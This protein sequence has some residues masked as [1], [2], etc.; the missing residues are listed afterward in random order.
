MLYLIEI[1]G[2]CRTIKGEYAGIMLDPYQRAPR[3][4]IRSLTRAHVAF[5]RL[6]ILVAPI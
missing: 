2:T 3:L 4:Y 1:C 5:A 6:A